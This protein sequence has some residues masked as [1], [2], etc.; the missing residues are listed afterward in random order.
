[1]NGKRVL[2]VD[3][4]WPYAEL[5]VELCQ[6]MGYQARAVGTGES[7]GDTAVSWGATVI[8]LDLAMPELDG[9]TILHELRLHPATRGLPVIVI[10]ALADSSEGEEAAKEA[11]AVF[12]KPLNIPRFL[13]VLKHLTA[14]A[15]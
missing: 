11:Q 15:A 12:P 4:D 14:I 2:V 1:M 9:L 10:S 13:H 3:D 8:L 6:G 5:L 7:V